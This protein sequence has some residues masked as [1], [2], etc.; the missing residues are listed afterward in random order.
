MKRWLTSVAVLAALFC[1]APAAAE[2]EASALY[3]SKCAACH[4]GD[5]LGAIGPALLPDNLGRLG[6]AGAEKVIREGRAATQMPAFGAELDDSA[7]KSLAA[8][9][10][11]KPGK[12]PVWGAREIAESRVLTPAPAAT[13]PIYAADPLNLFVVVES[14]DHHVSILDGDTFT[15]LHR[16]QSRF[17]LHGGPKFTRDGRYVFFGSRDGWVTKF[18]LWTL[19]I[20]AEARAGINTRN[21]AL[22]KDAKH[23]AVANYLPNTLV[24]LSAEDLSVERIF[25][26]ADKKGQASRVSAVYQAPQ[27]DSFIAAL[28]DVPEIWEVGTSPN[29]PPVYT[30]LVHSYEKGMVEALASS[31]GLFALRRIEASEPLDDFF[32]DPDYRNLIGA[33]RNGDRAIVVNLNTGREIASIPLPGMPHLGSG[34]SWMRD[35]HRVVATPHLKEGKVSVID[36][37]DWKT[38]A[39]IDTQGPGFFLR[40]HENSPYVWADSFMSPKNRDKVQIIDKATLQITRVMQ[41]APGKTTG[42]VEFDRSGKHALVSVWEMDGAI[43]V[44]DAATFQEVKRLPMSKPA[45]KYNIYNKITFSEGTSH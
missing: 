11:T 14:G 8:L 27:R 10:Y 2:P 26:V 23:L 31:Q 39:T 15:P 45:G 16:F 17:A 34:V 37:D 4:G 22:S 43:I 13:K 33:N 29:S 1:G 28:K 40:S 21:I 6:V 30:G 24:I 3:Q 35:G 42:H 9:V 41:P 44:Y 38:I 25:D 36:T 7:I 5:R 19:K 12:T 18:D 20:V 32:F